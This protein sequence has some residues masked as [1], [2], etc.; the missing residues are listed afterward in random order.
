MLELKSL[1]RHPSRQCGLCA[2]N[3]RLVLDQRPPAA[4]GR[5]DMGS[6]LVM[7]SSSNLDFSDPPHTGESS[8]MLRC[9]T[10]V[11]QR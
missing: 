4:A 11:P 10:G 9:Y 3:T 2:V 7:H 1:V 5:A 8:V 6:R